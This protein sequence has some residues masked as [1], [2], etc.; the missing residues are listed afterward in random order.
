MSQQLEIYQHIPE[1]IA[2]QAGSPDDG[3][4]PRDSFHGI[5]TDAYFGHEFDLSQIHPYQNHEQLVEAL[6]SGREDY[7]CIAVDNNH[8]GRVLTAITALRGLEAA[9]II[10]KI[11]IEVE[12][13]LLVFGTNTQLEDVRQVTSQSPALL[14]IKDYTDRYDWKEL[15]IEDTVQSAV[16]VRKNGGIIGG[17]VTA[18]VASKQA[19]ERN[20]LSS[21]RTASPEGNATTFWIVTTQPT[22][23]LTDNPTHVA[24]TF[25]VANEAGSLYKAID[26]IAEEGLNMTDLDSHLAPEHARRSFF[27]ELELGGSDTA[28]NRA[29]SKL[30]NRGYQARVHGVY[31]DRT[32][33]STKALVEKVNGHLPDAVKNVRWNG[34]QGWDTP[35]DSHVLY[36][37]GNNQAGSLR[38]ILKV[39]YEHGVNLLDLSRPIEAGRGFFL[40]IDQAVEVRPVID[41]LLSGNH[42][43]SHYRYDSSIGDLA[44]AA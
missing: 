8:S 13:Q 17:L 11:Q 2:L 6:R 19:G 24:I 42:P 40:V 39:P 44:L 32:H 27:A 28:F 16:N 20:G 7:I 41:E 18:A 22:N 26:I 30:V 15:P 12:Q 3:A 38:D 21:L 37:T 1:H 10:G 5:A 31:E 4:D 35:H 9:H 43:T 14:Q 23:P 36:V 29:I 33:P 34:R 25:N